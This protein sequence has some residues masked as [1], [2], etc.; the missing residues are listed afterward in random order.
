[1]LAEKLYLVARPL[2]GWDLR[3]SVFS[4]MSMRRLTGS[5]GLFSKQCGLLGALDASKNATSM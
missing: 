4:V 5:K 3:G 1:M 2:V